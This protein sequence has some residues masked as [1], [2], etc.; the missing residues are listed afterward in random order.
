MILFDKRLTEAL[1]SLRG[2]AGW[3]A[4]VLFANPQRQV[5]S[6]RGPC[7]N[8]VQTSINNQW[9]G[10]VIL[11]VEFIANSG[12]EATNICSLIFEH[13]NIK[14]ISRKM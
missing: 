6:R 8:T 1:I 9:I 13:N 5:F 3:S 11:S 7:D 10:K 2:C 14:T 4:P 12:K